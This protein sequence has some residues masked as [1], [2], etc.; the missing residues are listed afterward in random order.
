M[1]FADQTPEFEFA[2]EARVDVAR[3]WHIGRGSDEKLHF[4]PITGGTVSGPALS[5]RVVAGGGDWS[6][7]RG[8]TTQLEARYLLQAGDGSYIDVLNRGY[9]RAAEGAEDRVLANEVVDLDDYYFRT[10]PVFQTDAPAHRWLAENQF[11]GLARD[12]PGQICIRFFRIR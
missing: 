7:Q 11:V 4:T 9:F 8:D 5:G 2:F 3:G 10:S 1:T 6:V 12:E